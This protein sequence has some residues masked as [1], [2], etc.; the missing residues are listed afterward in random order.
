MCSSCPLGT[1][2]HFMS[3]E[4]TKCPPGKYAGLAEGCKLCPAGTFSGEEGA[5]T[6]EPCGGFEISATGASAC[7]SC[8]A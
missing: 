5:S 7:T 6:C 4:C 8:S 3:G 1:H 2:S